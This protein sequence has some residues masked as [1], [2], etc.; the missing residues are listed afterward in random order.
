MTKKGT[1]E[2]CRCFT[3]D[4]LPEPRRKLSGR[5]PIVRL[6]R[7]PVK[8]CIWTINLLLSFKG[9]GSSFRTEH[10]PYSTFHVRLSP[11]FLL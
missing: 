9:G 3:D 7:C 4:E 2:G 1:E 10:M 8:T 6:P 11:H 5:M